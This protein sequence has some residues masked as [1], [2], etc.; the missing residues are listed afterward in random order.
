MSPGKRKSREGRYA[1]DGFV[2][3]CGHGTGWPLSATSR[4]GC[5]R[6]A[7]AS[8]RLGEWRHRQVV[9]A[10]PP[11]RRTSS[12]LYMAVGDAQQ[13]ALTAHATAGRRDGP[14][15]SASDELPDTAALHAFVDA[16]T[17]TLAD[18]LD[19]HSPHLK[20]RWMVAL[21]SEAVWAGGV[22]TEAI[23]VD[24]IAEAWEYARRYYEDAHVYWLPP[25]RWRTEGLPAD[26]ASLA[27]WRIEVEG[28]A[29]AL[30]PLPWRPR[31]TLR[32]RL[33]LTVGWTRI[34]D[35]VA[36]EEVADGKR[37]RDDHKRRGPVPAVRQYHFRIEQV[38]EEWAGT[39]TDVGRQF[40]YPLSDIETLFTFMLPEDDRFLWSRWDVHAP[41]SATATAASS[42]TERWTGLGVESPL[43]LTRRQRRYRLMCEPPLRPYFDC[44]APPGSEEAGESA[45]PLG[46]AFPVVPGYAYNLTRLRRNIS[47][48]PDYFVTVA[49]LQLR[50]ALLSE[51]QP[52]AVRVLAEQVSTAPCLRDEWM[53]PEPMD[54]LDEA[55]LEQRLREQIRRWS[56]ADA[57]QQVLVQWRIPVP[58]RQAS[59]RRVRVTPHLY[60]DKFGRGETDKSR[61]AAGEENAEKSVVVPDSQSTRT[62][63]QVFAVQGKVSPDSEQFYPSGVAPPHPGLPDGRV[64]VRYTLSDA[65]PRRFAV[66]PFRGLVTKRRL[67]QERLQLL[68]ALRADGVVP[69]GWLPHESRWRLAAMDGYLTFD[70]RAEIVLGI[71]KQMESFLWR[72]EL[73]LEVPFAEQ[74]EAR[75][76]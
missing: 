69:P 75:A 32:G 24:G 56:G 46:T 53:L 16:W 42:P 71:Y 26:S 9:W 66:R 55:V 23:G 62:E 40:F 14:G 33:I 6:N 68:R 76:G 4:R 22:I 19:T 27:R 47:L 10:S 44:F 51:M 70:H 41:T 25:S 20:A 31:I 49:P 36:S 30:W 3:L 34:P 50:R 15:P 65:V 58:L 48:S 63:E 37:V 43:A 59:G 17:Q 5:P 28:Y 72:N 54:V 18:W 11:R 61:M 52:T 67:L 73:M 21:S 12:S 39:Y 35:L 13:S 38:R 57:A 74:D 8:P 45:G 2:T 60:A 64:R 7:V 29:T 1:V